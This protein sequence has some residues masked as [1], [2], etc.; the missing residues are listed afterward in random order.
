MKLRSYPRLMQNLKDRVLKETLSLLVLVFVELLAD[1]H[2]SGLSWDSTYVPILPLVHLWSKYSHWLPL[3][4]SFPKVENL[5]LDLNRHGGM[6]DIDN[7]ASL[8]ARFSV[9]RIVQLHKVFRQ[10]I[11]EAGT[12]KCKPPLVRL[13]LQSTDVVDEAATYAESGLSQFVSLIAKQVRT[14]EFLLIK[15][16]DCQYGASPPGWYANDGWLQIVNRT[17]D[18]DGTLQYV[19]YPV[20]VG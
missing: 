14:L 3:E 7:L 1:L 20:W 6:Y 19:R 16:K 13:E 4:S 17:W 2:R 11:F 10:L 8:F 15:D 18:V 5:A 9:L 12:E